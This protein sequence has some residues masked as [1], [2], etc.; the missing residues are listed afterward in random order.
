MNNKRS[1]LTAQLLCLFFGLFGF[2]RIY[3]GHI[4]IGVI[5][6]LTGGGFFIWSFIDLI[7]ISLGKYVDVQGDELEGYDPKVG[8]TIL[9]IVFLFF[10]WIIH[11]RRSEVTNENLN[12]ITNEISGEFA[13]VLA[14][15]T[16][17]RK[18]SRNKKSNAFA[19]NSPILENISNVNYSFGSLPTN[20][21]NYLKTSN[22]YSRY[23]N[24]GRKFVVYYVGA[25][26]PYASTFIRI[27]TP[28][29]RSNKFEEYQFHP[30][31]AS[32]MQRYKTMDEARASVAFSNT[33]QEFCIVNPINNKIFRING[34]GES[35]ASQIEKILIQLR[36]W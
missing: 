22:E 9:V 15:R 13:E 17:I 14:D 25:D 32:G 11:P 7:M 3:T 36:N 10:L 16:S 34:I 30:V 8:I 6:L 35:E 2:H 20:I 4:L 33:C 12:E 23:Y 26:C 29:I 1:Y 19:Q 18:S 31:Q 21:V 5:Q 28:L 27:L 24:D